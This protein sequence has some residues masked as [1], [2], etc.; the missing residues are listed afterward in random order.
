MLYP[1]DWLM[2]MDNNLIAV[3]VVANSS[4]RVGY[5]F[6]PHVASLAWGKDKPI[7]NPWT[8]RPPRRVF[9]PASLTGPTA[10]QVA[11]EMGHTDIHIFGCDLA[12]TIYANGEPTN[13]DT[14]MRWTAERGIW[15]RVMRYLEAKGCRFTFHRVT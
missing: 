3:R 14:D 9:R 8:A 10:L 15:D 1:H 2:M 6:P 4:P 13:G 7:R 5:L 11:F 12:G